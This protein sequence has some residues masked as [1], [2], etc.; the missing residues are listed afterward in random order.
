MDKNKVTDLAKS[1]TASC[2]QAVNDAQLQ[3]RLMSPAS[4]VLATT[5]MSVIIA[6]EIDKKIAW[7]VI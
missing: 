6:G 2:K 4:I 3:Q 7:T 1:F 5:L